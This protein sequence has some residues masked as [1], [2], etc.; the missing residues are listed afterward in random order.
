[1]AAAVMR[2]AKNLPVVFRRC[3][4]G[5]CSGT[6]EMVFRQSLS[7]RTLCCHSDA[8]ILFIPLLGI[9]SSLPLLAMTTGLMPM[10]HRYNENCC[11]VV[12]FQS[13]IPH[14]TT[15]VGHC[16]TSSPRALTPIR[17]T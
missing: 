3:L 6:A 13:I 5:C 2:I 8:A 7:R 14:P 11:L 15:S 10:C 12:D 16:R 9:A 17:K 1:M 4:R